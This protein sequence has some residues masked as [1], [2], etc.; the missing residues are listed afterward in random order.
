MNYLSVCCIAKDEN[1]NIKEWLAY[2]AAIGVEH[3]YIYDN[4]SAAPIA[5]FIRGF[6]DESQVTCTPITGDGMQMGVYKDCLDK[7]GAENH[8]IAF[9]DMDEFICPSNEDDLRPFLADYEQYGAL[10]LN[11][12]IFSSS[13]H[14]SRPSGL[15]IENYT[16]HITDLPP[17]L[18]VKC[19]VRPHRVK[20]TG[21]PHFFCYKEDFFAVNADFVPAPAHSS[22]CLRSSGKAFVHHYQYKSQQDFE[23]KQIR[24]RGDVPKGKDDF[25]Y[26]GFYYQASA[27]WREDTSILRFAPKVRAMLQENRLHTSKPECDKEQLAEKIVE[28]LPERTKDFNAVEIYLCHSAMYYQDDP[29]LW[30]GRAYICHQRGE[31]E[32]ALRFA[33]YG[34][35]YETKGRLCEEYFYLCV[36]LGKY[37]QAAATLE[38]V[39]FKIDRENEYNMDSVR[40]MKEFLTSHLRGAKK[41]V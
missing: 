4:M 23:N 18:I 29:S 34:L 40:K 17:N 41:R 10:A 15:V 35:Q 28:M 27:P 12:K 26:S 36:E 19:I 30:L 3:F 16:H 8:W 7:Y 6:A 20:H 33:E 22:R 1:A 9:I 5:D 24:G 2:H 39:E 11:W 14:L 37:E 21:N 31:L 13:G 38:Y 25:P 32:R